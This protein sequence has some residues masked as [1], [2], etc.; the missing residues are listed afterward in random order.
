MLKK[1]TISNNKLSILLFLHFLGKLA[2]EEFGV[3]IA[4]IYKA[5]T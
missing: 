4:D 3:L 5:G 2:Y 1:T